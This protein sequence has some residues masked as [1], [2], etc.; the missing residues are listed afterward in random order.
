MRRIKRKLALPLALLMALIMLLTACGGTGEGATGAPKTE[1]KTETA[2]A[3]AAPDTAAPE[4]DKAEDDWDALYG[5]GKEGSI[6]PDFTVK[7]IGDGSFTLSEALQDHELVLINLWATWCPPCRNEFPYLEEAWQANRDRVA[8]LALSVEQNDDL[9]AIRSFAEENGL[10][11]QMGRDENLRLA[12]SF[13]VNA[14]PTSLLVD[15]DRKVVWMETGAMPS[16][17]AFLD[18]F[19]RHLSAAPQEGSAV[20]SV[21]LTD[22]DG[23]AVPGA[24]VNFC[25]DDACT[26]VQT[27]DSGTAVF[28]GEP[29]AYHIQILTLPEGYDYSGEELSLPQEGGSVS[30]TVSRQG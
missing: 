8:V 9:A 7:T 12:A 29:Y 26:P 3:T 1:A 13:S 4:T 21:R 19:D 28:R 22:Q 15:R 18:L 10:H 16:T 24:I 23:A 5:K 11:F 2:A 25:T 20:Y 27:D 30:V 17:Q 6:L 14:I